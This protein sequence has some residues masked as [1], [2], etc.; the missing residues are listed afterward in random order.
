MLEKNI[1][2]GI[3][4]YLSKFKNMSYSIPVCGTFSDKLKLFSY[5]EF[6]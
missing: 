5:L 2:E 4:N 6:G 1:A 3:S